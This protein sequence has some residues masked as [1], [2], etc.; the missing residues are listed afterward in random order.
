MLR[1][2]AHEHP[3]QWDDYLGQAEFA[4]NSMSNRSTGQCPF[5]IVYTKIPNHIV[6]IAVLPKCRSKAAA[7]TTE[8]YVKMLEDVKTK[9]SASN[10]QYKEHADQRRRE[11]I[12]E[13]GELVMV[14][15]RKERFQPGTY[16]KLSPRRIGPV[17]ILQRINN[18]A[19]VV[20]LPPGFLTPATFNVADIIAYKSADTGIAQIHSSGEESLTEG[21]I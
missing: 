12:F 5:S 11:Q 14:R 21:E 9:L 6:D 20:D 10:A 2:I 7:E 8:Q 1:C 17:P 15:L 16:S 3:K 13:P 4:Y 19:Y 18:N